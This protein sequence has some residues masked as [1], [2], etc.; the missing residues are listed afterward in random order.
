MNDEI[1]QQEMQF[2]KSDEQM[3][4]SIAT[5]V[6]LLSKSFQAATIS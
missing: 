3:S 1:V 6:V 5:K 2:L 4:S